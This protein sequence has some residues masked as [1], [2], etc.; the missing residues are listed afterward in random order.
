MWKTQLYYLNLDELIFDSAQTKF[1]QYNVIYTTNFLF[2]LKSIK[3]KSPL[4]TD[5][6]M[7]F[8]LEMTRFF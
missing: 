8:N 2:L 6:F 7:L 1:D 5:L 4:W 3:Q